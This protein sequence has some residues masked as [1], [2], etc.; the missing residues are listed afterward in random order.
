VVAPQ[1]GTFPERVYAIVTTPRSGSTLRILEK[2][3]PRGE[4]FGAVARAFKF[5]D[6]VRMN[7]V[8]QAVSLHMA[9]TTGIWH[10]HN[11]QIR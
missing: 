1:A 9:Q 6:L 4:N 5:I 8:V 11:D 3:R 7:R 2:H 10:V